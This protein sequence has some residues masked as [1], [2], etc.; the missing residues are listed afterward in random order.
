MFA[1]FN[2]ASN[3][4]S[5]VSYLMKLEPTNEKKKL[6]RSKSVI[7]HHLTLILFPDKFAPK[8]KRLKLELGNMILTKVKRRVFVA[9]QSKEL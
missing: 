1:S 2:P 5:E 3:G 7:M 8:T 9:I 4:L 6:G